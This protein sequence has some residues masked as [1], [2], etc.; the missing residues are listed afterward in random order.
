MAQ[1]SHSRTSLPCSKIA[2]SSTS[3][4]NVGR[5]ADVEGR[6]ESLDGFEALSCRFLVCRLRFPSRLK[7]FPHVGQ[8]NMFEL[9]AL[10]T[11]PQVRNCAICSVFILFLLGHVTR[12]LNTSRVVKQ[13][14]TSFTAIPLLLV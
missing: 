2:S 9:H 10:D 13:A 6:F 8:L 14:R 1:P 3:S 12:S 4:S 5:S 7:C 11:W